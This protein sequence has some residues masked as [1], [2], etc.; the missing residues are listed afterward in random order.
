MSRYNSTRFITQEDSPRRYL[1]T[2]YP[3]I[4]LG[5]N[6]LY[7]YIAKGDRYDVLAREYY[8]DTTLWWVISAANPK[9]TMDTLI[10]EPGTQLRIPHP[11]RIPSILNAY[12]SINSNNF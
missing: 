10:P 9:L 12:D 5:E 3:V 7:V 8:N 6:D 1:T 11:S 2:K 4:P